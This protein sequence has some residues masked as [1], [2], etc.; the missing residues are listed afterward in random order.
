MEHTKTRL[1]TERVFAFS[2]IVTG[3]I[4]LFLF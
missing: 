4:F 3:V 1:K 2:V